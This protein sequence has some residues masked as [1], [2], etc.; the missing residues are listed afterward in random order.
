[1]SYKEKRKEKIIIE[2][3][4][5]NFTLSSNNQIKSSII[6]KSFKVFDNTGSVIILFSNNELTSFQLL[7]N[8]I[9]IYTSDEVP[10]KLIFYTNEEAELANEK[11]NRIING[12]FIL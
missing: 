3:N 6:N 5:A 10:Y 8:T 4:D 1:M 9:S 2:T 7:D 12:E 11:I